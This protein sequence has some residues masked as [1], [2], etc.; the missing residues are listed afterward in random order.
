MTIIHSPLLKRTATWAIV[1]ATSGTALAS[2]WKLWYDQPAKEWV[3]A[4]P[5][6]NGRLGAMVFGGVPFER[7]QFNESTIWT[8]KPHEYQHEGAAKFLPEMRQLIQEGRKALAEKDKLTAQGLTQEAAAEGK[9]Y[10]DNQKAAEKIG[11][12]NFMSIPLKQFAYQPFGD[13][14]IDFPGQ[15]NFTGY[16]RELDLDD[17]ISTVTYQ[18]GGVTFTRRTLASHPDHAIAVQLSADKPGSLTFN[19]RLDSAHKDV[20]ISPLGNNTLVLSGAVAPDGVRFEARLQVR[21]KGREVTI[22]DG[23][24]F[25]EKADSVTLLLVGASS[26]KNFQDISADPAARCEA[27]MKALKG[28]SFDSILAAHQADHRKLFRRVALDLGRTPAANEPTDKRIASFATR[29]DPALAALAFQYGRYLT[30]AGSRSGGMPNN[31]QGI[32]NDL[33]TP[34]WDSKFTS[35]INVEMNYWPTEIVNLSE[36]HE[37]LFDAVDGL[38]ISGAKTAKAQYDARGWVLHHNFDIWLGTAP[39][40]ASNHGIWVTGG[41]WL[42]L[43]LWEHYLFT[44]DK[45][46]LKT[47]AY[48]AMKS[49]SEFFQDY[50]VKDAISGHLISGPSN[51][52]EHGG[53]VM[54]PTMD[55]QIIRSLFTSTAEAADIL[56]VDKAFAADLRQQA[57]QIAPNKIGKFGQLQEWMEDLD[58]PKDPH[59]HVSHL[60]GV[61]P[62]RDITTA[63]KD[64]FA[65]ARQS[66]LY[67]GDAATGWSMGW[68]IN[69][70]AR[71]LDGDH[72]YTILQHLLKPVLGPN[73]KPVGGG[74]M[75]PNLFDSCPPFQIDGNFGATAG[76]AEM[77]LQSH[78]SEINLLP[79]LPKVWAT[80]SVTGLRARGGFEVDIAWKDGRLTNATIRNKNSK[81][82]EIPV[83]ATKKIKKIKLKPGQAITLDENL[84]KA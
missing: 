35:N 56:G 84:N 59:R 47:R 41:A 11:M 54:G 4:L 14:R 82:A 40:N 7:I 29:E 25:V 24:I 62:G 73:G 20:T 83:R 63:D 64:L 66:L 17:A 30:I 71:F 80:G 48:P 81:A 69:L 19:A 43:H 1:L 26:Y 23:R 44:N 57:A 16:R 21:A 31:L 10:S 72:A 46:F 68:K 42:C 52:P 79:A 5:V 38:R 9:K 18:S 74:G 45:A 49:A 65:A 75:C 8:G 13:L 67:R 33:L 27:D 53:L 34:P 36:C 2:D 12:D 22:R 78:L 39:I 32:W 15:D 28:K 55:H 76:I 58:D 3:E 60:W 70:W 61:Y 37:P 51:S 77:L 50:L 6:G